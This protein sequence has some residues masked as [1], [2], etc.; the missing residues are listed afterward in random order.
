MNKEESFKQFMEEHPEP[1]KEILP[2]TV[3]DAMK[4]ALGLT[5]SKVDKELGTRNLNTLILH[6]GMKAHNQGYENALK[7][8]E[9][10]VEINAEGSADL[11]NSERK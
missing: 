6:F 2:K 11:V 5:R 8:Q 4:A 10:K 1:L 7:E 9:K 3:Y